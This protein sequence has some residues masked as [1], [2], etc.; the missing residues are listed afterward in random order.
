MSRHLPALLLRSRPEPT[1]AGSDAGS[2]GLRASGGFSEGEYAPDDRGA[3]LPSRERERDQVRVQEAARER[4]RQEEIDR[5]G[6]VV[7][8]T[9]V[10]RR[11]EAFLNQDHPTLLTLC[12]DG[13]GDRKYIDQVEARNAF[14]D[15]RNAEDPSDEAGSGAMAS[16]K[17]TRLRGIK[18]VVKRHCR[19]CGQDKGDESIDNAYWEDRMHRYVWSAVAQLASEAER[20]SP[21]VPSLYSEL[22]KRLSVPA[23]MSWFGNTRADFMLDGPQ[24]VYTVQAFARD[25]GKYT[26]LMSMHRWLRVHGNNATRTAVENICKAYGETMATLHSLGLF[27]SDLHNQNLLVYYN[28]VDRR[29]AAS[30]PVSDAEQA[31]ARNDPVRLRVI[32]WGFAN[33]ATLVPDADGH[34]QYCLSEGQGEIDEDARDIVDNEFRRARG[35]SALFAA[36]TMPGVKV[37]KESRDGWSIG[38]RQR[39]VQHENY[40]SMLENPEDGVGCRSERPGV[41]ISLINAF[42]NLPTTNAAFRTACGLLR[43]DIAALV[44]DAYRAALPRLTAIQALDPEDPSR[45]LRPRMRNSDVGA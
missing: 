8:D 40:I 16:T 13:H 10:D 9:T 5:P 44:H 29:I 24:D 37:R 45:P 25:E 27:H 4:A 12:R 26:T 11:L 7:R 43:R 31:A 17:I 38:M 14:N 36:F 28:D 42:G 18:V 33:A 1:D 23:C 41:L 35:G 34:P 6:A 2:S 30:E 20:Q 22:L 3:D 15:V 19:Q 32:D 39:Y 21:G